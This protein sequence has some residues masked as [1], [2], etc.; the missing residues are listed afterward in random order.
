ML[1]SYVLSNAFG[2]LLLCFPNFVST[3]RNRNKGF[4]LS[5][6]WIVNYNVKCLSNNCWLVVRC[7]FSVI[8]NKSF[9]T[10]D[11][12]KCQNELFLKYHLYGNINVYVFIT[13][14]IWW[15]F[16][17]I[18]DLL[19]NLGYS[20]QKS[21]SLSYLLELNSKKK[22]ELLRVILFLNFAYMYSSCSKV[23]HLTPNTVAG[24][25]RGSAQKVY[26][27]WIY[28]SFILL[29]SYPSIGGLMARTPDCHAVDRGSN[30]ARGNKHLHIFPQF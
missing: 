29:H 27:I 26:Q 5:Q 3:A 23:S 9:K 28:F 15:I 2:N 12:L 4:L 22:N 21:W 16:D 17:M 6:L 19:E 14:I 8:W 18:I 10:K 25:C 11:E 30:P 13:E 24:I 7:F 1:S 20:L